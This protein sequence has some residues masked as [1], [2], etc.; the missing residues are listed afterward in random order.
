MPPLKGVKQDTIGVTKGTNAK[1]PHHKGH[2]P[3]F[4]MENEMSF[5]HHVVKQ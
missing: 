4:P 1:L 3:T 5:V 2:V